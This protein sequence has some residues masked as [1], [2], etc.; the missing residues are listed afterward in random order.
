MSH[1][2]PSVV[3]ARKNGDRRARA[4]VRVR[5]TVGGGVAGRADGDVRRHL[6][7]EQCVSRAEGS[8]RRGKK[9]RDGTVSPTRSR[10]LS[11]GGHTVRRVC[12]FFLVLKFLFRF[13]LFAFFFFVILLI[14]IFN[15]STKRFH[16]FDN[17]PQSSRFQFAFHVHM[18]AIIM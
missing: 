14:I 3:R 8:A 16:A 6:T 11:T 2:R 7:W 12:L 15:V 18:S 13:Y 10:G 9:L 17:G 5:T 1:A 4:R